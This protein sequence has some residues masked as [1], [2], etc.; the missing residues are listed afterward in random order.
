MK[1]VSEL[2]EVVWHV[3]KLLGYARPNDMHKK[4]TFNEHLRNAKESFG[5]YAVQLKYMTYYEIFRNP[6]NV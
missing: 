3:K 1:N 2:Y 6:M 4:H 5:P